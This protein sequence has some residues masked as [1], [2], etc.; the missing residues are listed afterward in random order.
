MINK[1]IENQEKSDKANKMREIEIEKIVLSIGAVEDELEKAVKLLKIISGM[2][3][4]KTRSRKRIPAFDIRP[5]L[6]IGCK[7][8]VRKE[9]SMNLLK[10]LLDAVNDKLKEKQ[11]EKQTLSFG[12]PEYIEIPGL[13][14][15]RDIGMFGLNVS[16]AFKRKGKRTKIKKIKK[17]KFPKRQEVTKKEIIKFMQEN[18]NTEIL[19]K[20]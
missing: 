10:R 13:E 2:K 15:Q 12:I 3:A 16:V 9:K 5:G 20:N 11:I 4:V 17:G 6:E 1:N 8:T 19:G 7:V 18:F 14:Y